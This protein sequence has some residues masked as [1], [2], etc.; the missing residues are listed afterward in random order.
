[1]RKVIELIL[2]AQGKWNRI[3]KSYLKGD[4]VLDH[5]REDPGPTAY[6]LRPE[7]PQHASPSGDRTEGP[8]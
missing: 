6:P 3:M 7:S 8:K 4:P 5:K 2:I 1:V